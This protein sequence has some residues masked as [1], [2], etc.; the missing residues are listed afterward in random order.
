MVSKYSHAAFIIC[1]VPN[2]CFA[3]C[4][5]NFFFL[6]IC[7]NNLQVKLSNTQTQCVHTNYTNYN[8]IM[9]I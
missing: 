4:D 2:I 8:I 3:Y 5:K 7:C 1:S 6:V 9:I